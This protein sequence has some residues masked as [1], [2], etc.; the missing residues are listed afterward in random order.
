MVDTQSPEHRSWNMSRIRGRDTKPEKL[1][2]SMLF[3]MGYRY[4]VCRRDLPGTPDI[5]LPRYRTVIFVHGCFWHRHEG[6]RFAYNP[7][8]RTEFWQ[9]KFQRNIE[10]DRQVKAE[11]EQ[12]G[13]C[14]L[15]VWECETR[16]PENLMQVL[17]AQLM[18][19][20]TES[21]KFDKRSERKT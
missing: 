4:R 21:T 3:R 10:R 12:H 20:K 19:T 5:V 1:V 13:W 17:D 8:S 18:S 6:C 7:K 11:L 2:R 16:D 15:Y 14:V 9:R